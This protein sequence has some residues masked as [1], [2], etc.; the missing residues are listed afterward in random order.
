MYSIILQRISQKAHI[1]ELL[2][3]LLGRYAGVVDHLAVRDVAQG[4]PLG[5]GSTLYHLG[6]CTALSSRTECERY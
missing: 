5:G 4:A 1:L 2:I 6:R 3:D